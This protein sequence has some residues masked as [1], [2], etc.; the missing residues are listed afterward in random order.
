MQILNLKETV[1]FM[2]YRKIAVVFSIL[3]MAVSVFS[4]TTNKLNFG[5]DFTGG[6]LLEIGFEEAAD[7]TLIFVKYWTKMVMKTL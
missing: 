7:L 3:L 2:S 6:T 5:L 1:A 4:L